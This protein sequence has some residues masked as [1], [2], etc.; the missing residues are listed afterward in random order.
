[1]SIS[2]VCH[3]LSAVLERVETSILA[4]ILLFSALLLFANVLLRYLFL[5]P[6]FWA[7]ELAR[8]LMVWMIFLGAG[9]VAG[10]EGHISVPVLTDRLPPGLRRVWDWVVTFL[11]LAFCATLTWYSLKHTLRVQSARQATAA[12]ELPMWMAYLSLAVGGA[13]MTLR[14]AIRLASGVIGGDR[15]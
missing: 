3:R 6:I 4:G 9:K 13:S 10:G 2:F 5:H 12:L 8:Y 7:E 1:M 15:S 11:C 14:Y